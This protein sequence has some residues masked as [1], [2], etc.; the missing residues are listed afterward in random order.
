[1]N[2]KGVG[3]GDGENDNDWMDDNSKI[4]IVEYRVPV[5][6]HSSSSCFEFTGNCRWKS[7]VD[8]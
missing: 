3:D 6:Q 4:L 8:S 1:M 2:R 5:Y 7:H